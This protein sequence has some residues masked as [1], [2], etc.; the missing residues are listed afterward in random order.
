MEFLQYL[1]QPLFLYL[2]FQAVNTPLQ[3]PQEYI[4]LYPNIENENRRILAGKYKI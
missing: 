2:S 4:D 1:L 3:A